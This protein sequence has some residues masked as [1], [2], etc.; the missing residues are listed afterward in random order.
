MK[1]EGTRLHGL[2]IGRVVH[3]LMGDHVLT[4]GANYKAIYIKF[5]WF[6]ELLCLPCYFIRFICRFLQKVLYTH[7]VGKKCVE[8]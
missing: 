4:L 5:D 7:E 1:S 8:T 3:G 6:F 2:S